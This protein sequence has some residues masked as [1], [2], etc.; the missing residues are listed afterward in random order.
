VS[1]LFS[2]INSKLTHRNEATVIAFYELAGAFF[3]ITMYLLFTNGFNSKMVPDHADIVYLIIL[4][5]ICTSVAYAAGVS[6]M[7]EISVFRVALITNLEPVYG[8]ILAFIFFADKNKMS[9]GFWA[10]A[11]IICLPYYFI[12][13]PTKRFTSAKKEKYPVIKTPVSVNFQINSV[14]SIF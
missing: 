2:I 12:P 7:R 6:V 1:S 4:G 3:W 14:W 5:T 11:V 10:G 8:I 13:L 9:P